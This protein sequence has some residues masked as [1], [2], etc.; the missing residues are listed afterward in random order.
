MNQEFILQILNVCFLC[1]LKNTYLQL[2][3]EKDARNS[4]AIQREIAFHQLV[5]R[6]G[7]RFARQ[8]FVCDSELPRD[9]KYDLFKE[10][11]F[12]N[13]CILA[14]YNKATENLQSDCW[15]NFHILIRTG[16]APFS[17]LQIVRSLNLNNCK[18]VS[19]APHGLQ[20]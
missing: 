3:Q 10:L 13:V 5:E 8:N 20:S 18:E 19:I 6:T 11:F 2:E 16:L 4:W 7:I 1:M 15:Q 9:A 17:V 12:C 14:H